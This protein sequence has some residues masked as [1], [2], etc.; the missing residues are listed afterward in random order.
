MV[1]NFFPEV[2]KSNFEI[3]IIIIM[4]SLTSKI[5]RLLYSETDKGASWTR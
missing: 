5:Y 1:Y 2:S 4:I 3:I